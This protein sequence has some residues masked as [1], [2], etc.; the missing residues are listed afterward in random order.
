MFMHSCGKITAIIPDLI[1]SGIDCFQF[2]QPTVHGLDTLAGFQKTHKITYWSPVDIQ[3]T[4][5]TR[6]EYIIRAEAK[7]NGG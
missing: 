5:Q 3:K 4:L 2:D 6:D 7:R 1:E